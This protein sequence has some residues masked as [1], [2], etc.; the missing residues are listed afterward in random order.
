MHL[1]PSCICAFFLPLFPSLLCQR[2]CS[3]QRRVCPGCVPVRAGCILSPCFSNSLP[4]LSPFFF[5]TWE[6]IR[7]DLMEALSPVQFGS[8]IEYKSLSLWRKRFPL[9]LWAQ[10]GCAEL[11][12]REHITHQAHICRQGLPATPSFPA[13]QEPFSRD[14]LW[15]LVSSSSVLVAL[16][17]SH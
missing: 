3:V 9:G 14:P 11:Y 1:C 2:A 13:Q 4:S 12:S 17:A 6:L 15:T 16:Q 5:V 10:V 7:W 8:K